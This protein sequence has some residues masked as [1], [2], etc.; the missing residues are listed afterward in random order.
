G[1]AH[2]S[3][4]TE[5]WKL[6]RFRR[7]DFRDRV[8]AEPGHR[9]IRQHSDDGVRHAVERNTAANYTWIAAEPFLPESLRDHRDIG[10]L[11]FIRQEVPPHDRMNAEKIEIVG[12][13]SAPKNLNR[14]AQTGQSKSE[15][16]FTGD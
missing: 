6:K 8:R 10:A 1:A 15:E 9:H 16:V 14:I 7:P 12:G 5:P 4:V 13:Q 2:H 11:F 3:I